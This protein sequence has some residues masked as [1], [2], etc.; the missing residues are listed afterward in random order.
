M[1]IPLILI[2]AF[3]LLGKRRFSKTPEYEA[4]G[5][6]EHEK[7]EYDRFDKLYR[8]ENLDLYVKQV[9]RV[10]GVPAIIV[11]A[12]IFVESRGNARALGGVQEIGLMQITAGALEDFN[13]Y[14]NEKIV[15]LWNPFNNIQVGTGYLALLHKR[16]PG[17]W[18]R[19]I[20]SYNGGNPESLA[21]QQN[22]LPKVKKAMR[23]F[24]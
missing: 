16:F 19:A 22:Y 4:L 10:Y 5:V 11:K 7:A 13:N 17:H 6:E 1:D 3:L 23:V 24:A 14:Y 2:G 20:V 8:A 15:D 18:D 12:I 21:A 9:T